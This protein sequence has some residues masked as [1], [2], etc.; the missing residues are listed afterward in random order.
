MLLV[1]LSVCLFVRSF[2]LFHCWIVRAFVCLRMRVCALALFGIGLFVCLFRSFVCLLL[3]PLH[4]FDCSLGDSL[5][6]RF[7]GLLFCWFAGLLVCWLGGNFE[8]YWSTLA[9]YL[10]ANL[11]LQRSLSPFIQCTNCY[12]KQFVSSSFAC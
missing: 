10:L 4:S 2:C 11:I 6:P 1:C 7:A 3:C 12:P 8:I 5:V 9:C